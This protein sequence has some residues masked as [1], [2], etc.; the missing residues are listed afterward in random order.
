MII[1]LDVF[2]YLFSMLGGIVSVWTI[3]K[4]VRPYRKISWRIVEKGVKKLKNDLIKSNYYPSIII[5]IGRG[6][7]IV[8]ALI[9]GTLGN[10]PIVVIDRVYKWTNDGRED[11]FAENIKITKNIEKV[12]LVSGE[13]HSGNTAKK[14]KEY[15]D[16]MGATEV[17]ILTFM[18]EPFPTFK[19]DFYYIETDN[20]NVR[21]PWMLSNEY[22]RESK[23]NYE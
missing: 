4:W 20:S 14:Y 3:I 17:R 5:G 22:K 2:I 13:L 1:V 21:F 10:V 9:S 19:P 8:G 12:L 16:K 6:G 15:F 7:S 18:K 23:I 11:G